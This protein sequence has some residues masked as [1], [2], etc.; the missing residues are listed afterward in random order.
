MQ[1]LMPADKTWRDKLSNIFLNQRSKLPPRAFTLIELLVV[2]A[3]IAILAAL[4][5]PV[6][7][8]AKAA[9][10]RIKCTNNLRQMGIALC[11]YVDDA[12]TYPPLAIFQ[13][14]PD[15][16]IGTTGSWA[17]PVAIRNYFFAPPTRRTTIRATIGLR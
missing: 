2:I 4:L 14:T 13:S 15:P 12:R 6:L 9:A 16:L 1:T 7:S 5:L 8:R 10:L 3:V 17:I 11:C